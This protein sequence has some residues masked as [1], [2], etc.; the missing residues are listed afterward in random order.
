MRGR[1]FSQSLSIN[2]HNLNQ[3]KWLLCAAYRAPSQNHYYFFDNI[4]KCLDVYSTYERVALAGDFNAQVGEKLFDTFLYQREVT[5]I[6]RYPRCYKNPNNPICIDHIL[7][8]S[9]MS[10]F[11]QKLRNCFYWAIRLS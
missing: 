11:K 4:D 1:L 7:P 10:F 5:S 9:P 8:N 6:N 2:S 3:C